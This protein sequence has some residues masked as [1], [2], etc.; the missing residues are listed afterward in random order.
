MNS[1]RIRQ[2]RGVSWHFS[3]LPP[4]LRPLSRRLLYWELSL[5]KAVQIFGAIHKHLRAIRNKQLAIAPK[6]QGLA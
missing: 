1:V 5:P 3:R 6:Q 4:N 2:R